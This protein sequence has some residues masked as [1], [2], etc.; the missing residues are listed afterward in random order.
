MADDLGIQIGQIRPLARRICALDPDYA[1]GDGIEPDSHVSTGGQGDAC[2]PVS[3]DRNPSRWPTNTDWRSPSF[4]PWSQSTGTASPGGYEGIFIIT[5]PAGEWPDPNDNAKIVR[6]YPTTSPDVPARST[7]WKVYGINGGDVWATCDYVPFDTQTAEEPAGTLI[8]RSRAEVDLGGGIRVYQGRRATFQTWKQY[9]GPF[10]Y[11]G[12]IVVDTLTF[13]PR[14]PGACFL[15][16]SVEFGI[17][18]PNLGISSNLAGG[19]FVSQINGAILGYELDPVVCKW[20]SFDSDLNI[21]APP[22]VT[23]CPL[24]PFWQAQWT[25]RVELSPTNL[26]AFI[27]LNYSAGLAFQGTCVDTYGAFCCQAVSEYYGENPNQQG[28]GSL[29]FKNYGAT[30]PPALTCQQLRDYLESTVFAAT[31]EPDDAQGFAGQFPDVLEIT[32]VG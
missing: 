12:P 29:Y 13:R 27:Q 23:E 7:E 31:S 17:K 21:P 1:W 2:N 11:F 16:P 6:L 14:N 25:A 20:L 15:C 28:G 4:Q 30:I 8:C 19:E 9:V 32:T 3:P 10:K 26:L 18:L 22:E 5:D 24:A